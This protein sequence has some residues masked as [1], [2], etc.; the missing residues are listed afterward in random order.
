MV[1]GSVGVEKRIGDNVYVVKQKTAYEK[2]RSLVDSEMCIRDKSQT[3]E[4]CVG[5]HSSLSI[6]PCHS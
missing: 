2:L 3:H 6:H 5:P 1:R 4:Y